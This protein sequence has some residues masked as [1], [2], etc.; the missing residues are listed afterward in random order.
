MLTIVMSDQCY[1]LF[2]KLSSSNAGGSM[3]NVNLRLSFWKNE[4]EINLQKFE[5]KI[6]F[7]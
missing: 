6:I 5:K 3:K 7:K 2:N 4:L 1:F